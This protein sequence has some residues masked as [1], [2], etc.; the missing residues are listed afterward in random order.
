MC[1]YKQDALLFSFLKVNLH[2]FCITVYC[3]KEHCASACGSCPPSSPHAVTPCSRLM[4]LLT[5]SPHST[6]TTQG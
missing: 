2:C 6:K 1:D 3:V 4:G 5:D